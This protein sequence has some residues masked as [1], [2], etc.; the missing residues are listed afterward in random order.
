MCRLS[1]KCRH[2]G[3]APVVVESLAEKQADAFQSDR[4]ILRL[5]GDLL[6]LIRV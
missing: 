1:G 6:F 5:V 3:S 4:R 2:I